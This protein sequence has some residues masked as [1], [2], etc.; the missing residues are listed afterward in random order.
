[1]QSKNVEDNTEVII[2]KMKTTLDKLTTLVGLEEFVS[3]QSR[4][5][6]LVSQEKLVELVVQLVVNRQMDRN[7]MLS[8]AS[9]QS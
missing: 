1:M 3:L 8:L 5:H 7:V 9:T 4:S 6:Y 2:K